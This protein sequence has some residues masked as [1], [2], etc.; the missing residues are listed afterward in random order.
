M[1]TLCLRITNFLGNFL[2]PNWRNTV[3]FF[4][5]WLHAYSCN[6]V[7]TLIS[8]FITHLILFYQQFLFLHENH[9]RNLFL[10]TPA[11]QG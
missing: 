9:H 3:N 8:I 5:E 1:G 10:L 6:H 11:H 7:T 4:S 2:I